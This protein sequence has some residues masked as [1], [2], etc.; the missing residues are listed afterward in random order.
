MFPRSLE[1]IHGYPFLEPFKIRDPWKPQGHFTTPR[2]GRHQWNGTQPGDIFLVVFQDVG[3]RANN[4]AGT[5][6]DSWEIAKEY[7]QIIDMLN[8]MILICQNM[9]ELTSSILAKFLIFPQP[10][11][12][13]RKGSLFAQN[14]W[15]V[16][17]HDT[18]W[19]DAIKGW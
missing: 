13:R 18:T 6:G 4:E 2:C 7:L 12:H 19:A 9:K 10:Q 8:R 5:L 17:S 15:L 16:K 14:F 11:K 1:G 3:N